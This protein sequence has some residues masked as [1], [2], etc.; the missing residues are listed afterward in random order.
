M[1]MSVFIPGCGG[2]NVSNPV[3]EINLEETDFARGSF[4]F[5]FRY[6]AN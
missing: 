3:N 6:P 4:H 5:S 1:F 2:L